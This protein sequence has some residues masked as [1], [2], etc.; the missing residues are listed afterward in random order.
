MEFINILYYSILYGI[1]YEAFKSTVNLGVN[2]I[3][4][5]I[6]KTDVVQNLKSK[7]SSSPKPNIDLGDLMGNLLG[8]MNN[9]GSDKPD[10]GKIL[11]GLFEKMGKG[12]SVKKEDQTGDPDHTGRARVESKSRESIKDL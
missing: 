2:L 9:S 8:S 7:S 5:K 6:K 1:V 12:E 3:L 11:S 10:V 4:S